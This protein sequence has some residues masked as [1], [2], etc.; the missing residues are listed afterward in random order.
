M[1][2]K[3]PSLKSSIAF[4][5]LIAAGLMM[6]A[7]SRAQFTLG[8]WQG[9]SDENWVRVNGGGGGLGSIYD[10]ANDPSALEQ[11][12]G[13][14]TG[15]AKSLDIKETGYGNVRVQINITSLAGGLAAFTNNSKLNFTFSCPPDTGAGSGYMQLA[16]LQ[17]NSDTGGF[18][19]INGSWTSVGFT[20]TGDTGN[21]SGSGQPNFYFYGG[22]PARSQVVTW[23]YSSIKASVGNNPAYLQVTFVWNAGGGAPTNIFLNNVTLSGAPAPVTTTNFV[24]DNFAPSGVKSSNAANND[25][26]YDFKNSASVDYIYSNGDITNVYAKWF[27]NALTNVSWD[28]T[29][30]ANNNA[31]SGA[32]KLQLDWSQDSQFVLWNQGPGNN[33]FQVNADCATTFTNLQFDVRFAPG[34]ASDIGNGTAPGGNVTGTFGHLRVGDRPSDYSQDWFGAVDVLATNTGWVHVSIPLDAVTHPSLANLNGLIFG[35]DKNYYNLNLTGG[36]TLW[37]DN[38]K[39]VGPLTT[40]TVPPPTLKVAKAKPGLRIFAGSTQN[41]YDREE[42]ATVDQQQSFVGGSFPKTY[43][44]TLTSAP[45]LEGFQTHL[46]LIP[47]ASVTPGNTVYN[48]QYV[49]YQTSNTLWLQINGSTNGQFKANIAWKTNL[50]NANPD[51]IAVNITNSTAVGTWTV[52]FNSATA[53]TLTAPGA[54]PA[55]FTIGDPAVASHFANPVVAIFGIQPQDTAYYGSFVDYAN[56]T[57]SGVVGSATSDDFT[58]Q[59]SLGAN[60]DLTDSAY[61]DSIKLVTSGNPYWVYWNLPDANFGLGTAPNL[62]GATWYLLGYYNN[63]ANGNNAPF[64]KREGNARWTLVPSDTLPTVNTTQGGTVSPNGFYKLFNPPLSN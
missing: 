47:T 50:P 26:Y 34:S 56:I 57:I 14:V 27:G 43:S 55:A 3:L 1:K 41:T 16:E 54:S 7:M 8:S 32:M 31:S 18:H 5:L 60:W 12:T 59:S 24:I 39:L 62:T 61:A 2:L 37:I 36:S 13:V 17:Y 9:A 19:D 10:P 23:D 49:D 11:L 21:N 22:A 40:I 20:A 48:N 64:T 6:P 4:G 45:A 53:G 30:D 63:Y 28:A 52:T 51:H 46:F 44:F 58:T 38:I 42:L 33:Y 35:I 15:Y 25:Y 29:M